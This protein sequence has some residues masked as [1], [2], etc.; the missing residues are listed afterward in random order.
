MPNLFGFK[1]PLGSL[2]RVCA[3]VTRR[4]PQVLT[5][6]ALAA[7]LVTPGFAPPVEA[8]GQTRTLKL[9]FIHTQEKAQITFKRNGRYDAKGLQEIN[10]FLRDWRRNEPTKMDPRLLDLV[11]E[12]YQKS[13]SRDYIHVVSAYRSPATNGMLRSRSKGVAKKSQHMLGKA[14]DFYLPDVKLKTLREIGVKFQVGGVGYYPTSGSPFVHMDVGGVRAWPRMSRAELARLFP[15]GKTMHLPSDGKPL[16][17]YDQAVADYKRRVGASAIQVAGG[18]DTGPGDTA[19]G[20]RRGNL[21]AMLFGGGG[22]EDEEPSAIAAGP[23]ADDEGGAAPAAKVQ[24]AAAPAAQEA[25]PGV[26]GS[27]AAE[28]T[29]AAEQNINAPVPAV[30]PA[31]KQAPADGGVAVALV[32][33]EKSP[34]QE[35]L[36]AALPPTSE[37]PSEFADLGSMKVPV[38]QMLDRRDMNT[39]VASADAEPDMQALGFVPVPAVRPAGDAALAAV[40]D[41]QVVIPSFAERP[42]VASAEPPRDVAAEAKT[43]VALAQPTPAERQPVAQPQPI[44][45]AAYAP[46]SGTN[47]RAAIFDSA[48]DTQAEAP[49]KGGRP[50]KNDAD[51]ATRSSVRAE[52]KLTQKIIS[53][54]ALSTG[55][56]ATLSKPVKAPRFVSKSL[57]TAPTTVYAA[58]F[59]SSAGPN[60]DTARFSGNAVNFMEVKKFST[61]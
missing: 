47:A 1:K 17:G 21:F 31:F 7:A 13:G 33:P 25:L 28:P 52:P 54:W 29:V 3:A 45:M 20:K 12:V 5:S 35:A 10:R 41:A 36:A 42:V 18:G 8:A 59:S 37:M 56:V 57:R 53:E 23:G 2:A 49:A 40:A 16:P 39:L 11:W 50:K 61:N 24:T 4:V 55:R 58:G 6:V 9:Y 14:M 38:P 48:F 32:A 30:R 22:D 46:Q 51:A 60:V 19:S 43:R 34:A 44:E 26:A 27:V 15:D